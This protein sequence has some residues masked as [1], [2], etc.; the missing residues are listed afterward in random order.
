MQVRSIAVATALSLCFSVSPA[1]AAA[2][3]A[4]LK[5]GTSIQ[6]QTEYSANSSEFASVFAWTEARSPE[7]APHTPPGKSR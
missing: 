1:L 2:E 5:T 3:A 7:H 6:S 4:P